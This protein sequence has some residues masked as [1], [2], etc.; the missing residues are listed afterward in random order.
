MKKLETCPICEKG[1]IVKKK[2][3]YTVYGVKV[4]TYPAEVCTKCGEEY[5]DEPTAKEIEKREIELGLFGLKRETK[6]R[7]IGSSLG[8]ILPKPIIKFLGLKE[9]KR[10]VIAPEGKHRLLVDI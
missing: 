3:D 9:E 2:I 1:K 8:I 4:G 6:L 5:F 10:A 7:K